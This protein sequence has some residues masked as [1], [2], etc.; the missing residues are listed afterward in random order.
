MTAGCAAHGPEG[1]GHKLTPR[2]RCLS[3]RRSRAGVAGCRRLAGGAAR[4]RG[5]GR[6]CAGAATRALP[7]ICMPAESAAGVGGAAPKERYARLR[8]AFP[9]DKRQ[10]ENDYSVHWWFRGQRS[11][12]RSWSAERRWVARRGRGRVP[13]RQVT[14]GQASPPAGCVRARPGWPGSSP[15][16]WPGRRAGSVA[17]PSGRAPGARR[18]RISRHRG[19]VPDRRPR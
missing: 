1:Q 10:R 14:P 7:P 13:G 17:K 16:G 11:A 8:Q 6:D 18:R 2:D 9:A 12:H 19:S 15:A 4:R 5:D 3:S